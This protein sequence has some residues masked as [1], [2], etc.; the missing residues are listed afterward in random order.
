MTKLEYALKVP[1]LMA[2]TA[3]DTTVDAEAA[4]R[5][6]CSSDASE[7]RALSWYQS[8]D[9]EVNARIARTADLE[10]DHI[11]EVPLKDIQ[12]EFRTVNLSHLSIPVSPEDP[13]YGLHGK[14]RNC[15]A[16]A[17]NPADLA[18]C[19]DEDE[20][21]LFGEKNVEKLLEKLPPADR[22]LYRTL[23]RS[24]FNPLYKQLEAMLF[25]FTDEACPTVELLKKN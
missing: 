14:Y 20:N 3:D 6:F 21:N 7:R 18:A 11:I 19:R 17:S 1:V 22:P 5:F 12:E 2:V 25:C 13:H 23:R 9:P 16:Y 24:T 8:I 4:R 15:L 10:C